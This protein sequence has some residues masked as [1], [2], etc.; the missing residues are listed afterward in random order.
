MNFHSEE[1]FEPRRRSVAPANRRHAAPTNPSD[2][3]LSG[4]A[5]RMFGLPRATVLLSIRRG[6]V[7]MRRRASLHVHW[8]ACS[9]TRPRCP[10]RARTKHPTQN[11]VLATVARAKFTPLVRHR[12][13]VHPSMSGTGNELKRLTFS[14]QTSSNSLASLDGYQRPHHLTLLHAAPIRHSHDIVVGARS[15]T[16]S[17][18]TFPPRQHV[19]KRSAFV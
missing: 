6:H 15:M 14:T 13:Y 18:E 16:S 12:L 19:S 17:N 2:P 5:P 9:Q 3:I 7:A 10:V 11:F 1:N 8:W 4:P